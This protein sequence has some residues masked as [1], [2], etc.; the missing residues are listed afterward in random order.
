[1]K[2]YTVRGTS[3]SEYLG[4]PDRRHRI[5]DTRYIRVPRSPRPQPKPRPPQVDFKE[6]R[7]LALQKQEAKNQEI[8]AQMDQEKLEHEQRI[9]DISKQA[10]AERI[11]IQKRLDQQARENEASKQVFQPRPRNKIELKI[12]A[13]KRKEH[14]ISDKAFE[15]MGKAEQAILDHIEKGNANDFILEIAKTGFEFSV[16]CYKNV[17]APY[18]SRR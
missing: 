14:K 7:Q 3:I 2:P 18:L 1:M 8:Y 13:I 6:Q 9:K 10:E 17:I 5:D 16:G 11:E 15:D 4:K 12:P